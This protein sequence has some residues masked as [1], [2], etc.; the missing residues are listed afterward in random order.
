MLCADPFRSPSGV[1]GCGQCMPCRINRRRL[2]TGRLVLEASMHQSSTFATLTYAEDPGTLVPDHLRLFIKRL[3]KAGHKVRYYGVGEYGDKNFRPH[4]HVALFGVC[5]SDHEWNHKGFVVG[6]PVFDAWHSK[7]DGLVGGVHVGELN[8][9]S[10]H[11]ICGYVTKKM[12]AQD[13][14]RLGGR[15]P[16]FARMSLRPGIGAHAAASIA[17]NL[18]SLGASGRLAEQGDVPH[19]VRINGKKYPLG[20][21]MRRAIREAVGWNSGT[22]AEALFR[23]ALK[24]ALMPDEER[25][26]LEKKRAVV[27]RNAV[28]RAKLSASKKVL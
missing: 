26:A 16:E 20:R 6:G 12:T 28:A 15:Y 27:N 17:Q 9:Q 10:A 19:E 23:V 11:Y 8:I 3:R 1:F 14:P 4:Y 13:D 5:Y 2:W 21:Y 7:E 22:P 24:S 25:W 18:M